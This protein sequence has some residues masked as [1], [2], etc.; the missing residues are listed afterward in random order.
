V[1]SSLPR[2]L[3]PRFPLPDT[4][5]L[6]SVLAERWEKWLLRRIFYGH[7]YRIRPEPELAARRSPAREFGSRDCYRAN[8]VI[9]GVTAR[10]N[11][12][13]LEA[14]LWMARTGS[15]WRDLPD[16]FGNWNSTW[17]RFRR[18]AL[19]GVFE[20]LFQ[21]MADD[22]DFEYMIIDETLVRV[23]QHGSKGDSKSGHWPPPWRPDDQDPGPGRWVG[24]FGALHLMARPPS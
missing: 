16:A 24:Q 19:K 15:P 13:F 23:H 2:R 18:W 7:V 9:P 5:K 12:G 14:V 3:A 1:Y 21:A 6:A 4:V 11:R 22:P 17:R 20:Q 8:P 10:D